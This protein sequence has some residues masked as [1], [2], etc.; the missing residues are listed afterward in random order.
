[1]WCIYRLEKWNSSHRKERK[2]ATYSNMA[3]LEIFILSEMSDRKRQ[4][5][6]DITLYIWNLKYDTNEVIYKTG[7]DSQTYKTSLW[8][9]KEKEG[10]DR[11]GVWDQQSQTTIYKI[12]NNILL[13]SPGS[14][15]QYPV[16]QEKNMKKNMY[17]KLN[18]FAVYHN[19]V[20]LLCLRI[21]CSVVSS[22]SLRPHGL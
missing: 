12:N 7:T 19:T 9:P 15:I 13:Y 8:L 21:S 11:L 20:N 5:S 22:D 10:R 14:Y 6:H 16:I 1:M 3:D 17:M 18:H 2:N 4:I